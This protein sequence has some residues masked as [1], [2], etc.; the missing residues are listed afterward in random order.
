LLDAFAS[1]ELANPVHQAILV[2]LTDDRGPD[3]FEEIPNGDGFFQVMAGLG[4][5]RSESDLAREVFTKL[6]IAASACP[7]SQPDCEKVRQV[8][9]QTEI[10]V[11]GD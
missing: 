6:R 10:R 3:Y 9:D 4:S 8:F 5:D 11:L 2:G 1:I 7:F